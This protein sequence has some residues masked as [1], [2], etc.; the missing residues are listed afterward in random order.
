MSLTQ[1][2]VGNNHVCAIDANDRAY[3][4]GAGSS[5]QL[6]NGGITQQNVP[7]LVVSSTSISFTQITGGNTHTCALD[8]NG[9]AY[10][11]G[12]GS[13]GQIGNGDTIQQNYPVRLTSPTG[14][15]LTSIAAGNVHSCA[16][17]TNGKAYCW[18]NGSYGNLGVGYTTPAQNWPLLVNAPGVSFTS[19][20][21]AEAGGNFTCAVDTVHR[22]WCWGNVGGNSSNPLGNGNPLV[23]PYPVL[24]NTVTPTISIQ[25]AGNGNSS[26][27]LFAAV[28]GSGC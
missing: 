3:C 27:G 10:C 16:V 4:W 24:I 7:V 17:D 20:A 23:Q 2:G 12:T 11:W 5:G 22:T 6:G 1:L 18:G 21:A 28:S 19:I 26:V 8:V 25:K 13:S 15:S 9:R 14:V